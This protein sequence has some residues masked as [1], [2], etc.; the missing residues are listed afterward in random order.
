MRYISLRK[1]PL[2]IIILILLINFTVVVEAQPSE[3]LARIESPWA[4]RELYYVNGSLWWRHVLKKYLVWHGTLELWYPVYA[5]VSDTIT[6]YVTYNCMH[7]HKDRIWI[8]YSYHAFR[9]RVMENTVCSICSLELVSTLGIHKGKFTV[10]LNE[11]GILVL[12]IGIGVVEEG[13][14]YADTFLRIFATIVGY[15]PDL[16]FG[17]Q[18]YTSIVLG[19]RRVERLLAEKEEL[20][21]KLSELNA[22]REKLLKEIAGLEEKVK[23][24]NSTLVE[25][26][27]NLSKLKEVYFNKSSE[28]S[29]LESKVNEVSEENKTLAA[30]IE[31]TRFTAIL[32]YV[33]SAIVVVLTLVY[34]KRKLGYIISLMLILLTP[35]IMYSTTESKETITFVYY[36][37]GL[38]VQVI[39][40]KE[41]KLPLKITVKFP[42][43]IKEWWKGADK[44]CRMDK[45][46]VML[47]HWRTYDEFEF[48]S[49]DAEVTDT[50]YSI[51]SKTDAFDYRIPLTRECSYLVKIFHNKGTLKSY[52]YN[53]VYWVFEGSHVDLLLLYSFSGDFFH[54]FKE[55]FASDLV[56]VK[57]Y[58]SDV[59]VLEKTLS[60]L[61]ASVQQLLMRKQ[62][63]STL[64]K[65]L[66]NQIVD[67]E[68]KISEYKAL[69]DDLDSKK[70]ELNQQLKSLI[71]E[72]SRLKAEEGFW[73]TVYQVSV[74][75][76]VLSIIIS[77]LIAYRTAR[78]AVLLLILLLSLVTLPIKVNAGEVVLADKK[79]PFNITKT[80]EIKSDSTNPSGNASVS[81]SVDVLAGACLA[82]N[83]TS[84]LSGVL[85]KG[86]AWCKI[87]CG[88]FDLQGSREILY[89]GVDVDSVPKYP[90][91]GI[92]SCLTLGE[93]SVS[94][95]A[96]GKM[97]Y[98]KSNS[99][100]ELCYRNSSGEYRVVYD[101]E[102]FYETTS[103]YFEAS[104]YVYREYK[105][106][107]GRV[108]WC[109]VAEIVNS[110][111]NKPIRIKITVK[112]DSYYR[113]EWTVSGFA[114]LKVWYETS[115][116]GSVEKLR[117]Y[118][119]LADSGRSLSVP[120]VYR[121]LTVP[122]WFSGVTPFTTVKEA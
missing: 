89:H 106:I 95:A 52:K 54:V 107:Y 105:A 93:S 4:V 57:Q 113:G 72:N 50:V 104:V 36:S 121:W 65:S 102:A 79:D 33:A 73:S 64:V 11:S 24:L 94:A 76:L 46:G 111:Y 81:V 60:S 16:S 56:G 108:Y 78:Y 96:L 34:R 31:R 49:N 117:F 55:I 21:L 43:P 28:V 122:E 115:G 2:L 26:K 112:T 82:E 69:I 22:S 66:E 119:I 63:L 87:E 7:L 86:F 67:G 91:Y 98:R 88:L 32:L 47:E 8:G 37:N 3:P 83:Y 97:W 25:L 118:A 74:V 48:E 45:T 1:I 80:I 14:L 38:K 100:Y 53:K 75:V 101:K 44:L 77:V 27:A 103:S 29:K 114:W 42:Y 99:I 90:F 5:N 71:E 39:Y 40:P 62:Q 15:S 58:E 120:V 109:G 85:V 61:N 35:I 41:F 116:G 9:N 10:Q 30:E 17:L 23:Q 84:V 51:Y 110:F 13:K 6:I 70:A 18:N 12:H 19:F 68:G 92:H 59:S 20:Q